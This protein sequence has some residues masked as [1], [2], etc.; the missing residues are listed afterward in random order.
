MLQKADQAFA[1]VGETSNRS[2]ST[3]EA[4]QKALGEKD[5][6]LEHTRLPKTELL[7][8]VTDFNP[9]KSLQTVMRNADISGHHLRKAHTGIGY[10]IAVHHLSDFIGLEAHDIK[11]V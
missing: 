9:A 5:F 3:G 8:H 1:V 4:L 2:S 7:W 6:V 10:Y 11:Y